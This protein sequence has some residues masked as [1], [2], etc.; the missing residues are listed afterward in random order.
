MMRL[1]SDGP[2]DNDRKRSISARAYCAERKRSPDAHADAAKSDSARYFPP[3]DTAIIITQRWTET[4]PPQKN[5]VMP[6]S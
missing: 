4:M 5:D 2:P 1:Y 3:I 6:R